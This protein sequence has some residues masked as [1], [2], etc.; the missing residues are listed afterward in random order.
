MLK[1]PEMKPKPLL[2][3]REAANAREPWW[4]ALGRMGQ[5]GLPWK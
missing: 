2:R 3:P 4:K 5:L 1:P